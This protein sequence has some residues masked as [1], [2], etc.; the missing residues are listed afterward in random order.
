MKY[1]PVVLFIV[2]FFTV[3]LVLSFVYNFY[4]NSF[5]DHKEIK[6]DFIT[7]QVSFQTVAVG[8]FFGMHI[9]TQVN[10]D[11]PSMKLVYNNKY[12]ARV[13][14]GCNAVS[15][16]IL[17]WAFIIAFS[18]TW[19]DTLVFGIIGTLLIYVINLFR[20]LILTWAIYYFSSYSEFSHQIVFPA[21][22]YGFTFL[23]WVMWVRKMELGSWKLTFSKAFFKKIEQNVK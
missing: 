11:E 8:T 21:I 2:K 20:I 22:I 18:G 19:K 17:F 15:V 23:L 1:K 5:E 16:I 6:T 12:V 9:Y 3:Y 10:T 7:Q 4:L 14:E 13:V